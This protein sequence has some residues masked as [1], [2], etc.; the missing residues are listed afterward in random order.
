MLLAWAMAFFCSAVSFGLAMALRWSENAITWNTQPSVSGQVG[1][2]SDANNAP[3]SAASDS[4]PTGGGTNNVLL[5]WADAVAKQDLGIKVPV[6][7]RLEGTNVEQGQ[8]ILKDS[9]LNFI[10][11]DGMK[12]AAEKV[13]AATKR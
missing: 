13:V 9:G 5:R 11:A 10:V 7:V 12:D 3:T 1:A 2:N 8:Q 6:V 4:Q